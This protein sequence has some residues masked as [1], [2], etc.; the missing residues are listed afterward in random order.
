MIIKLTGA[1]LILISGSSIGWIIGTSYLNRVRDLKELQTAINIFN[2]EISYGQTLLPEALEKAAA[3]I[4]SNL[5]ELLL[6]AAGSLK[7][8]RG[9]TFADIWT[10]KINN[11]SCYA[12]LDDEDIKILKNWGNQI[13]KSSL[14]EQRKINKLTA[15]RL[16]Q[17][18]DQAQKR[19]STRVKLVRYAGV[20]LSLL[21]IILFY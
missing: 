12:T 1:L 6:Q 16:E 17:Q 21:V 13:G 3:V 19:A 14:A 18:E 9:K 7:K 10:K 11:Y 8:S 4:N 2:T 5:G 15:K 20:L